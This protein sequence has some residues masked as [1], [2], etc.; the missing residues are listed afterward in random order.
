MATPKE[1]ARA[2]LKEI[3][4]D[5]GKETVAY[6][7]V[8][9]PDAI[10]ETSSTFSLSIR[11]VVYNEIMAAF[12]VDET[13]NIV[14]QFVTTDEHGDVINRLS[15]RNISRRRWVARYR[16]IRENDGHND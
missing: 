2:L 16:K 4:M 11:N 10:K 1:L 7:H 15:E 6:I 5:I 9:Y 3:A 14:P 8:M 13:G 12:Q